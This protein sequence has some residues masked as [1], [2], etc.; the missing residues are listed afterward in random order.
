[1]R[2]KILSLAVAGAV[3]LSLAACST[4]GDTAAPTSDAPGPEALEN[5]DGVTEVTLWH[6]LGAANGEA[7][8]ARIAAFNEENEGKIHVTP[9]YQGVYA[10]LLAKYTA[11]IRGESAPTLILA[12]DIATGYLIDV[13]QSIPAGDM[14]AA[15]PDDL[16]MDQLLP[17]AADYYNV[18]DTQWAVPV[19][20]STPMLWVNW[21]LLAQAGIDEST[22]LSTLDAVVE[23]A[24]TIKEKT[25][26]FGLTMP[27]DDWYIEQLT[28]TSGQAFCTPDNG[29]TGE[30]PTGITINEGDAK[31]SITKIADLYTSGVATPGA[32]D[33]SA[34]LASF[35]A[36][37]VGMML[38]S[39]GIL[40]SLKKGT[41]FNY[42]ALP[43]PLAGDPDESGVLIGGS[44]LWLSS[45]AADA[46]Q[47]AGWK[48][49]SY[50]SSPEAQEEFSHATG[51]V[52]INSAT[53]D[54]DT[55][56]AFLS[57]N[58]NFQAFV[59]QVTNVPAVNATTGCVT[60]AMTAIR[61]ANMNQL[62]AAYAGTTP[63]DEALDNAAED[64]KKALEDY[65][66]Q[67]G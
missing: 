49:A 54:S 23:A 12:G 28:A 47:V 65:Q 31:E 50:L 66:D 27:D 20:M 2:R 58:P 63:I 64:A 1:M 19:A 56:K 53:N 3:V 17:L 67:V 37:N 43:F 39:S 16:D 30:H 57:E 5:A 46:E 4:G 15:N 22:D 9:T 40:G 35:Q 6:G 33:G 21:D 36:G 18:D 38:Y 34:A 32:P 44:A 42:E 8:D 24:N 61:T 13:G 41:T 11:A 62:Q 29:R 14:A 60:G 55:Q 48:V 52:P 26:Q 51:Y 45:A 10:D 59:D 7:L 25:G